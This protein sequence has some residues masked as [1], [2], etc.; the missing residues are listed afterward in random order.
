VS[1]RFHNFR[2]I[3][4]GRNDI[5]I[6]DRV[7]NHVD[8]SSLLGSIIFYEDDSLVKYIEL[9]NGFIVLALSLLSANSFAFGHPL[10]YSHIS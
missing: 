5:W 4:S 10:R 9:L 8:F 6:R 3:H 1:I 2:D 7:L